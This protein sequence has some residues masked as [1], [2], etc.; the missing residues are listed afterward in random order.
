MPREIVDVKVLDDRDAKPSALDEAL[1]RAREE[2][3]LPAKPVDDDD[4]PPFKPPELGEPDEEEEEEDEPQPKKREPEEPKKPDAEPEP[5]ESEGEEEE[6][7]EWVELELPAALQEQG[8]DV[9]E[10]PESQANLFRALLNNY[11]SR[12]ERESREVDLREREDELD[13]QL[14]NLRTQLY[15]KPFDIIE[16]LFSDNGNPQD[17]EQMLARWVLDNPQRAERFTALIQQARE[18]AQAMESLRRLTDAAL[19]DHAARARD[20]YR[21]QLQE[22]QAAAEIRR[23][24]G[25]VLERIEP[26]DRSFVE[27]QLKRDLRDRQRE[28]QQRTG[29]TLIDPREV[30]RLAEPYLERFRRREKQPKDADPK[31]AAQ[32][33]RDKF[34]KR[35][36][37]RKKSRSVRPSG[38][39]TVT[40]Q[41]PP[42]GALLDDVLKGLKKGT[43]RPF[44]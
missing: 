21:A 31:A 41:A 22:R 27:A 38:T 12:Q 20:E 40:P 15:T 10:A 34:Q 32:A 30:E 17:G 11:E 24:L 2:A 33:A 6:E 3:G 1:S 19:R 4:E 16:R 23:Q 39:A 42:K 37:V 8:V 5:P 14:L 13:E 43:Y 35:V 7:E 25:A 44:D 36:E 29:S 28:Q 26:G 18:D 9:L